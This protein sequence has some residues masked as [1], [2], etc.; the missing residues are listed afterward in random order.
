MVRVAG[1][2]S[3]Y[4]YSLAERIWDTDEVQAGVYQN[5]Q[6]PFVRPVL[7]PQEEAERFWARVGGDKAKAKL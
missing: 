5:V 4:V 6:G 7:E 3:K 1:D 2:V